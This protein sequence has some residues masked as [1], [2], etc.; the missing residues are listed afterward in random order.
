MSPL[1]IVSAGLALPLTAA[2]WY[3][4]AMLPAAT[5]GA[6]LVVWGI[7]AAIRAPRAKPGWVS[8][9]VASGRSRWLPGVGLGVSLFSWPPRLFA[10]LTLWRWRR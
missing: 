4:G 2:L 3:P 6:A 1:T 7:V 9:P 8:R 5:V 10:F